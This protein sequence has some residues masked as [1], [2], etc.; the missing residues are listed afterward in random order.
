M[1]GLVVWTVVVGFAEHGDPRIGHLDRIREMILE[2]KPAEIK[3]V[4]TKR[5]RPSE[6]GPKAFWNFGPERDQQR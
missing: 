6:I 2:R 1:K 4:A 3:R 5:G